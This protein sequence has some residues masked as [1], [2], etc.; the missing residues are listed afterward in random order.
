[1]SKKV[2]SYK[3]LAALVRGFF[4]AFANGIIDSLITENDFETKND[5]RHIKQS[6]LKHYEEISSHFLDILF[7]ALARLNYADDG[8]M[9]TKLQETFQNK[10]PDMTEYLRFACKTDR[11]YEA[12]VTEYKRNFNMLLQGQ[13]TTI[14]E[15]FEAYSRGVQLSVVD[16]PMA[17]CIMVRVLLKA[18]AAGIKA[19]KTKKST[20][21]QVT[22]YRL[23]LLNIQLL[24]ND[25]P[26]K[27][28]SEDLMVLFK[29]ACRT[30]NNLNVL[31]NSLDDIYKELA[32]EDGITASNDQAN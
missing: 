24:L 5:P 8:K 25:G 12:M 3:A 32:E 31:F 10:Q 1:M 15:H 13:F 26:F 20:F 21:N 4:E 14:P 17:V 27:S 23:L 7:P 6:M 28:S 11:L 30:E 29:E 18:Y 22:V 2:N 16:E 19:S 9:Q